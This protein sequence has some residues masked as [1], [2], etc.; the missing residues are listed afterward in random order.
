MV[1]IRK[2]LK[3]I[4]TSSIDKKKKKLWNRVIVFAET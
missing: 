4:I 3:N 1:I 2:N